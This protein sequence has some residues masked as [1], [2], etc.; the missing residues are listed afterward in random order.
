MSLFIAS[1]STIC[2]DDEEDAGV[3]D[4][5]ADKRKKRKGLS[6]PH[7]ESFIQCGSAT[8]QANIDQVSGQY[9]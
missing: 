7:T 9:F 4:I 1:M 2:I 6:E 8:Q 5:V 3:Y